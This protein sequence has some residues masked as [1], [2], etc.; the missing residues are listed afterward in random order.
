MKKQTFAK[1]EW[2][3]LIRKKSKQKRIQKIRMIVIH[4]FFKNIEGLIV[5]ETKE[6]LSTN[7]EKNDFS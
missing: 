5:D 6:I 4:C 3:D 1:R 2:F 7:S